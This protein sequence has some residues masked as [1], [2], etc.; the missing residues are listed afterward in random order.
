MKNVLRHPAVIMTA[1]FA[2]AMVLYTA[3]RWFFFW[4]NHQSFQDVTMDDMLTMSIGGLRFDTSALCYI[5]ILCVLMQTLPFKFRDTVLY[6]KIVKGIFL[7][8]NT[9]GILVN[10]ADVVYYS[11]GGRRTTASFFDEFGGESNLGTILMQSVTEYWPVWLFGLGSVA[12]LC[13]C[14]YNPIRKDR[15]SDDYAAPALYY[16]LNTIIMLGLVFITFIGLRGGWALKMHPLRQD[17][18]ELYIRKPAHAAIVLNTPFT[19]LTTIHKHGFKNPEFFPQDTL[20]TI[21]DPVHQIQDSSGVMRKMNVVV[22]IMEGFSSEY[23]SFQN[24]DQEG[25]TPFLDSLMRESLTFRTSLANGIRSVDA[26]PGIFAGIPRYIEPYC[27]FIYANNTIQGLP[28]MLE[29]EGYRCG[30]YHGAPNTTLG[31][32]MFTNSIGFREYFGMDEYSDHSQFDGTWAIWDEPYLKYFAQ[33][34]DESS[35]QGKPFL[36]TVFT[37]SSHHPF[38]IPQEYEDGRFA[39]GDI[40]MHRAVRYS[41]YSLREFYNAV[42]DKDWARNTIFVFT[43]DHTGPNSRSDYSNEYG[44]FRIPIFFHTPGGQIAPR[45]DSTRIMQQTD[46]TPTLLGMLNYQKPCFSFGKNVCDTSDSFVNFAFNDLNGS[47]M[48]YQDSLMIEYRNNQLYGIFKYLSDPTL[49]Q[50]LVEQKDSFS[51]LP[52][53][54]TRIQAIIQ[55]YVERMKENKLTAK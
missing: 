28:E 32:K 42:K 37:A 22:V 46:I 38:A 27:Y 33:E 19:L 21:F 10:A 53:M 55:Q 7:S 14:Y 9:L 30:F 17:S 34:I 16:P 54:E 35:H 8:L 48:Y 6:Q 41:D 12:A 24:P 39:D 50:N 45:C 23:N 29:E 44:R 18:A 26:M 52:M 40:A 1:N 49:S 11:F 36:M 43:A 3:A 13:L 2:L 4:I 15:D 51:E 25:Y 47:S 31:F 5:N 20:Y